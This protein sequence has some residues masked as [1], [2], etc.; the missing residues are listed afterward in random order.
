MTPPN[1]LHHPSEHINN[2]LEAFDQS[3]NSNTFLLQATIQLQPSKL[4][5]ELTAFIQSATF[6]QLMLQAD[7]ERNWYNYHEVDYSQEDQIQV[8]DYI[9]NS[10]FFKTDFELQLTALSYAKLEQHLCN[11]LQYNYLFPC[12]FSNP[13]HSKELVTNFLTALIEQPADWLFFGLKP[14]FLKG[15]H[16]VEDNEL[17]YFD[18]F[19]QDSCT[20]FLNDNTLWMLLTNGRP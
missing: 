4:K 18:G 5:A 13:I 19:K 7:R 11:L 8:Y 2:L 3:F 14:N 12:W 20:L 9:P 10:D 17:A 6:E 16:E 15:T 1:N